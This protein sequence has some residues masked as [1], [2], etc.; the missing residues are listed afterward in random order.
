MDEPCLALDLG[1][2]ERIGIELGY[3]RFAAVVPDLKIM[4]ATYFGGL[5]DNL[6][7]AL[8]LPVAGL[9]GDLVRAPEQ[10]ALVARRARKDQVP[11]ALKNGG[12]AGTPD[13]GAIN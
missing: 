11:D 9:H 7:T 1:V 6:D 8:A 10:L 13:I 3:Q 2:A 12:Q 5:G 4:L